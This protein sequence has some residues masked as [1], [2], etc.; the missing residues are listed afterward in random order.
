MKLSEIAKIVE[1]EF[2]GEDKDIVSLNTLKDAASNELSFVANP[3]Y[4]KDIPNTNAG[5]V[6][7]TEATKEYVPKDSVALV[8]EDTYWQMAV[9]SQY[10]APP[11]EDSDAP[12][13]IIGQGS[14]VASTAT[15]AN[16]AVIG[17]NTTIM[18]GVYVGSGAQIGDNT[19]LYP[20][21]VVY[22]DCKVGNDC[23]IHAGTV[24]GSDGFGF[25]SNRLGEHKKIYHIGN[26]VIEDDVE[27]G[28]NT[29]IDRAVFGTTLIEKGAR[30][31]NLIQVAHNCVF[32][33]G[34]VAA[35]QSGF[36]GSTI[37]GQNNVFGAQSGTAGHLKIAPFNT[38]AARSGVTKSVKESGK[39]FA[40]FPFMDHKAW[41]KI[42]GKLARL[43]K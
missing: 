25:A 15:V 20:N 27:I 12:E 37:I 23:I 3:K 30:L 28:S 42:Q 32:G 21:V 10:F 7:V 9:L 43:I 29:S 22:R 18:P 40:G 1:A 31:D 4:V 41:L 24:V 16:G 26:V 35:A 14:S 13:A 36:A 19:I 2:H 39:T 11:I 38:F 5:A 33:K 17:K 8:V 34:S 6:L